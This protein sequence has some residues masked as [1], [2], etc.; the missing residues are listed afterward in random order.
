M[1]DGLLDSRK[2]RARAWFESLRDDICS[3]F[4]SVE[5]ALPA[6]A[7][8]GAHGA[9]QTRVDALLDAS[10]ARVNALLPPGRFVRTPWS[11]TDHTGAAGGGG[12]MA[13]MKGRVFE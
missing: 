10:Q 7:P 1:V 11:R 6:D 4:E 8:L 13:L 5:D 9:S 12:V 3:A 2:A